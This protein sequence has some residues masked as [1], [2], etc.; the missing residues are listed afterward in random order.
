MSI[1]RIVLLTCIVGLL[2]CKHAPKPPPTI[3]PAL[4]VYTT[5]QRTF[6][7]FTRLRIDGSVDVTLHNASRASITIQGSKFDIDALK[8]CEKDGFLRINMGL[9]YPHGG[10]IHIDVYTPKLT[11]FIYRGTGTIQAN[12]LRTPTLDLDIKNNGKTTLKGAF[13]IRNVILR[14]NSDVFLEHPHYPKT[15]TNQPRVSIKMSQKS[16]LRMVG[17]IRLYKLTLLND[18]VISAYWIDSDDLQVCAKDHAYVQL[19]GAVDRLEVNLTGE[20]RFNGRYLRSKRVFAKTFGH[21]TAQINAVKQQHTLA[22]DDSNIYYY[23]IPDA[24]A[25]FMAYQGAVLDRREWGLFMQEFNKY[26]K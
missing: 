2:G 7:P 18:S 19:G 12:P 6:A 22:S 16:H 13:Y 15:L 5:Q 25:D 10:H 14:G 20:A 23:N 11:T 1:R 3:A 24:K 21:S 9:G 8:I 4:L 17:F 26:N